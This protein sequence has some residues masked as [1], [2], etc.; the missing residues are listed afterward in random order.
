MSYQVLQSMRLS[1]L[2]GGPDLRYVSAPYCSAR[3]WYSAA[4]FESR[5]AV[6]SCSCSSAVDL[7]QLVAYLHGFS[8]TNVY[9]VRWR[10]EAEET[11]S[12]QEQ[13]NWI[14]RA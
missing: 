13:E 10:V 5:F 3:E 11:L 4:T 14:A 7:L 8:R 1:G 6:Q 2:P 12:D 9:V